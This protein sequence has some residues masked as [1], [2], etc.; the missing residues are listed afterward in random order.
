M[1]C[2]GYDQGKI[3]ACQ[4]TQRAGGGTLVG[5]ECLLR[6]ALSEALGTLWERDCIYLPNG[7]FL[8]N[9]ICDME[10][11]FTNALLA[12]TLYQLHPLSPRVIAEAP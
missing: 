11:S 1:V 9:N 2:A 7:G 8:I 6:Q 5:S 12:D 10:H 3:D 4:V